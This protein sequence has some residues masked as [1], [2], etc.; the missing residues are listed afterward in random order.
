MLITIQWQMVPM[1]YS[2]VVMVAIISSGNCK[3]KISK[4]NII[5]KD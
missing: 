5:N 4:A 1:C 2:G 3:S